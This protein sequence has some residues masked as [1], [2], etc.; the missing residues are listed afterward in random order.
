MSEKVIGAANLE[1][2]ANLFGAFDGNIKAVEKKYQVSVLNRDGEIRISGAPD[3]AEKA[4][5][6]ISQLLQLAE[7]GEAITEQNINYIFSM[8]ENAEEKSYIELTGDCVCVTVKGKPIKPKTFGQKQ[9]TGMIADNTITFG[10]GPAGT[11]KTY[12]A[13]AMAVSSFRKK[14]GQPHYSDQACGGSGGKPGLSARGF[15]DQ[16]RPLSAPAVRRPV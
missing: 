10:I 16:G 15:A 13:V 7:Q 4:S 5:R 14:R 12:L 9:Y 6:V 2:V 1:A 3:N 8:V 11:G